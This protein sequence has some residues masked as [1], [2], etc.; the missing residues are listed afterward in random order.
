MATAQLLRLAIAGVL[1]A[2]A[3]VVVPNMWVARAVGAHAYAQVSSAPA[4]S[5]AI[6]PGAAVYRGQPLASL[7]GRLETALALYQQGQVK[8]ILISGNDSPTSPEV[9]VMRRWLA[10][11]DVPASDI[12]SDDHGSRT[13]N[14]ML[15]ATADFGVGDAIVCTQALYVDRSV[16]L[17]RQAGIDAVG[18]G[19]PS[20]IS[21]SLRN[22]GREML[23]TALAFYESYLRQGPTPASDRTGRTAV[24]LH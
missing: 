3:G 12:L 8:A 17:A 5:V 16:F 15:D 22:V 7:K 10:A 9:S 23:K 1:L 11:H 14:T 18:I 13:R 20:P 19:V 24:A 6:V 21:G 4:R 2:V